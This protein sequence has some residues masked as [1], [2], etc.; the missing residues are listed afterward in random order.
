MKE[1]TEIEVAEAHACAAP[2]VERWHVYEPVSMSWS[3]LVVYTCCSQVHA[4]HPPIA[5]RE[6]ISDTRIPRAA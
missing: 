6:S 1:L 4:E 5:P 3:W 2:T